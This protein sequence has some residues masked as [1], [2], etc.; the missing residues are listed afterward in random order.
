MHD[1]VTSSVCDR[2][3]EVAHHDVIEIQGMASML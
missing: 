2:W 3:S 1:E